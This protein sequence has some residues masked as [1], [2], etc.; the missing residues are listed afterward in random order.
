MH[1]LGENQNWILLRSY[2]QVMELE[3]TFIFPVYF[4]KILQWT[5]I[6]FIM[7]E[8]NYLKQCI[9]QNAKFICQD[10][11]LI[12]DKFSSVLCT[13]FHM[14]DITLNAFSTPLSFTHAISHWILLGSQYYSAFVWETGKMKVMAFIFR[15]SW[16]RVR[17]IS[18]LYTRIR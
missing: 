10:M 6:A 15:V 18:D 2:L 14:E 8:G 12:S 17:C 7:R 13:H 9:F 1:N 16:R 5:Y 4:P 3:I 11:V